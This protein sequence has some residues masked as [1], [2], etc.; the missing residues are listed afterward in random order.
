MIVT[1]DL[2]KLFDDFLAVDG[3]NLEVGAGEVLALLGPNGAGKT[4]TVRMLTSV[5]HPTSG[6]A[7]VAGYD[8]VTQA[9]QVRSRVGVLTEQLVFRKIEKVTLIRWG[10]VD[11]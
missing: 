10:S 11:G 6:W 3:I 8:V 5:L 1:H 2:T 9:E 7:R 4:T